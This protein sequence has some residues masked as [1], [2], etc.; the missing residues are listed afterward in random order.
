MALRRRRR[1]KRRRRRTSVNY[2]SST[3]L[4][5]TLPS[6][7]LF[8]GPDKVHSHWGKCPVEGQPCEN[9][10]ACQNT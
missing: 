9:P 7:S 1:R 2:D 6:G 8:M 5:Y 4:E 3:I 10:E